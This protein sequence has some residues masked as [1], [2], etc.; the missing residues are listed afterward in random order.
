MYNLELECRDYVAHVHSA[1][2][3][4]RVYSAL[5][6]FA[7]PRDLAS[8]FWAVSSQDYVPPITD[9]KFQTK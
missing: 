2:T 9:W 4:R 6:W 7:L 3:K 8:K 5:R 1:K